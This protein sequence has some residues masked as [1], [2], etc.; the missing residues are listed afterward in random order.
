[1]I[2]WVDRMFLCTAVLSL[3][4]EAVSLRS[5]ILKTSHVHQIEIS[6]RQQRCTQLTW[7]F[8]SGR[9][10]DAEMVYLSASRKMHS[11]VK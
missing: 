6:G 10:E 9:Q 5:R 7:L 8:S 1:M 3:I 2:S 11:D 4:C